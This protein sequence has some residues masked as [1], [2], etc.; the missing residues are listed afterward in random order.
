MGRIWR[1]IMSRGASFYAGRPKCIYAFEWLVWAFAITLM[2]DIMLIFT[3]LA[4]A[5]PDLPG[6]VSGSLRKMVIGG[7]ILMSMVTT[8][9]FYEFIAHRASHNSKQLYAFVASGSALA[10]PVL[11]WNVQLPDSMNEIVS[12]GLV[13]AA[14]TIASVLILF[15]NDATKWL[16]GHHGDTFQ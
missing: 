10:T 2:N 5:Y 7:V 3:A 1:E 8:Y 9:I 15:R 4:M 16:N 12:G 6:M 14:L 11:I 13:A